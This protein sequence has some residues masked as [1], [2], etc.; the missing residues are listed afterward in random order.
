MVIT[1]IIGIDLG[2]EKTQ[3]A[4]F[5]NTCIEP[6]I[7]ADCKGYGIFSESN[8]MEAF[9]DIKKKTGI[10]SIDA[11]V[12]VCGFF[13]VKQRQIIK[14]VGEKTGIIIKRIIHKS[15]AAA[16]AHE[17]SLLNV[18]RKKERT[19]VSFCIEGSTLEASV[20]VAGEGV[21]DTRNIEWDEKIN[22]DNIDIEQINKFCQNVVSYYREIDEVILSGNS[23]Y[24]TVFQPFLIKFFG[25]NIINVDN[26]VT[27]GASIQGLII[28]HYI[29]GVLLLDA[30]NS[31]Y[32]IGTYGGIMKR[33]IK[34]HTIFPTINSVN[35]V[36]PKSNDENYHEK[37]L[38]IEEEIVP[39]V[40]N[41]DIGQLELDSILSPSE[42]E[43]FLEVTMGI[44]ENNELCVSAKNINTGE[45]VSIKI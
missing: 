36:I 10:D 31:S 14:N 6:I 8:I 41:Y 15:S 22:Y 7:I 28:K 11:V 27:K 26:S 45:I 17:Y 33:L 44:D 37:L 21:L 38:I 12:A 35:F 19:I 13:S 9:T 25:R 1:G 40:Q 43:T 2:I 16:I 42:N 39:A 29:K 34:R 18:Q 3:A 23:K 30:T 32:A 4:Y 24:L 5:D 20:F